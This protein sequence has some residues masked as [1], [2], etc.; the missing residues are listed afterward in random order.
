MGVR[1]LT[2]KQ[3]EAR[4]R[5]LVGRG[6]KVQRVRVPGG[7]VVLKQCPEGLSGDP[8]FHTEAARKL[9]TRSRNLNN[10]VMIEI[11]RKSCNAAIR[12]YLNAQILISNARA[13]INSIDVH[14]RPGHF[15]TRMADLSKVLRASQKRIVDDCGAKFVKGM[16][17]DE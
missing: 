8:S 6:C 11:A 15:G 4:V 13:H 17:W 10:R 5:E 12:N 16:T 14:L 1:Q 3:S 2:R 7:T 9:F